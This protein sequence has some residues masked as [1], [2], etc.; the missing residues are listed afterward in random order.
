[1]GI[2]STVSSSGQFGVVLLG[3]SSTIDIINNHGIIIA[4]STESESERTFDVKHIN[5]DVE[6]MG[7][8]LR[9][10]HVIWNPETQTRNRT[11]SMIQGSTLENYPT[12]LKG[13]FIL[14]SNFSLKD[15]SNNIIISAGQVLK[16]INNLQEKVTTL[17]NELDQ[18]KLNTQSG[19]P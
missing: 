2:Q 16:T 7:L 8:F 19:N 15:K 1:M 10:S 9:G 18:L 5:Q 12:I 17:Q 3:E 14:D 13:H 6:G 11:S 4:G